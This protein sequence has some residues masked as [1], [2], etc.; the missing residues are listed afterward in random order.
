[1]AKRT[2]LNERVPSSC[3]NVHRIKDRHLP[4]RSRKA[5]RRS[6]YM[7]AAANAAASATAVVFFVRD[8]WSFFVKRTFFVRD[9]SLHRA[10]ALDRVDFVSRSYASNVCDYVFRSYGIQLRQVFR[11]DVLKPILLSWDENASESAV[12]QMYSQV[13]TGFFWTSSMMRASALLWYFRKNRQD[14]F[15][16]EKS[17]L[18]YDDFTFTCCGVCFSL[19]LVVASQVERIETLSSPAF[20]AA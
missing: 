5:R 3:V 2:N 14:P 9:F 17:S 8:S 20:F 4:I 7:S 13:S 18:R 19:H 11:D 6:F 15:V 1:M 12:S 10:V 16:V